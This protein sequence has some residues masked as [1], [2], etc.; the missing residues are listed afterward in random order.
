MTSYTGCIQT[1]KGHLV[2]VLNPDPATID[3]E[4]IAHSLAMQCRY[5]G[6]TSKF[7]S[8]A[9]HS[10]HVTWYTS[11]ENKL[12]GLL[13][14]ATE[15]YLC[16]IPRPI[17]PLL[18][19]YYEMEHNFMCVIAQKFGLDT[20]MPH[21]VKLVDCAMLLPERDALMSNTTGDWSQLEGA[22]DLQK[23]GAEISCWNWEDAKYRFLDTFWYLYDKVR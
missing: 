11:Q 23:F 14:D 7:Y 16:D 5:N 20:R 6:H 4:D 21:E 9:E 18:E 22:P 15:A 10:V 2:D 12:W 13:H 17:K 19:G 8:V 1:Y 3:I